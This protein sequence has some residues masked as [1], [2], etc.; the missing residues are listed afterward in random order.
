MTHRHPR[1]RHRL[2]TDALI[3]LA[4]LAGT[5]ITLAPFVLSVMTSLKSPTQMANQPVLTL[6][7]PVTG[8]NYAALFGQTHNFLSPLAVTFQVTALTLVV[9]L[10]CSILAAYAFARLRF[11]GR[12]AL[13]WVYL[14]TMMVPAVTIIVP[15]YGMLTAADLRNT[16]WGLVLPTLFG[17]PYAVFLLREHFR[18]IPAD[19]E[20]AATIDGCGVLGRLRHVVLP[21]SRPVVATLAVITVVTHWNNFM[22]PRVITSG[23]EWATLTV[24]TA[25]LQGQH[26]ANW[27]VVMAATTVSIVPLV[28]LYLVCQRQVVH[29]L[30][31][32]GFK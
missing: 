13:F 12:D 8:E 18:T 4:L 2:R 20:A 5:V 7:D 23:P 14:S 19:L 6:P 10:T 16:F 9:Q 21:L 24:A 1:G 3:Y 15:L 11:P 29:S 31:L 26:K 32:S 30:T 25:A 22:W 28:L 17:S 27:T